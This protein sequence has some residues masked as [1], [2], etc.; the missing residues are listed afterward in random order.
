MTAMMMKTLPE[1][2]EATTLRYFQKVLAEPNA[3]W[4]L[5]AEAYPTLTKC[6]WYM[7]DV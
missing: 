1:E 7:C 5:N 3:C 6:Q 4:K 2:R